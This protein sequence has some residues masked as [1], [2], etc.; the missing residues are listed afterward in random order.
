MISL[1]L[2]LVLAG[3]LLYLLTLIP[4]DAAIVTLIRVVVII[5]CVFYV[6]QAFGLLSSVP[7]PHLGK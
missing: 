5:A 4:M 2:V 3:V 7:V 6:I 1:L